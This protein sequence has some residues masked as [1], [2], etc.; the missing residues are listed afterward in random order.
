MIVV[1]GETELFQMIGAFQALSTRADLLHCR[2][3]H[4]DED[5]DD[6]DHH[7]EFDQRERSLQEAAVH[8]SLSMRTIT[9]VQSSPFFLWQSS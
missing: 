4:A 5:S 7:K 3:G 6:G 8:K 1:K 2:E 9:R